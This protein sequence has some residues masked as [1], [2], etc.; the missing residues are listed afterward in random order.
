MRS[1]TIRFHKA[2]GR[3]APV[4]MFSSGKKLLQPTADQRTR[5]VEKALS[6]FQQKPETRKGPAPEGRRAEFS[7]FY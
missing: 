7:N 5:M 4:A 3:A 2:F 1:G 6:N